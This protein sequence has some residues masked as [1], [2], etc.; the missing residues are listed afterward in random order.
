MIIFALDLIYFI[1]NGFGTSEVLLVLLALCPALLLL[2]PLARFLW[3]L[4]NKK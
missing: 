1:M 4:G 3:R 2:V